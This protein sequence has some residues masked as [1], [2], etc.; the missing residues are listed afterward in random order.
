L[1]TTPSSLDTNLLTWRLLMP[2]MPGV[3]EEATFPGN[4]NDCFVANQPVYV[5]V[6]APRCAIVE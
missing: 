5:E 4:M 2:C 1:A 6:D 3:G